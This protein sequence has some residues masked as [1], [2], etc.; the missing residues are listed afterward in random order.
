MAQRQRYSAAEVAD[1]LDDSEE[2]MMEGSDDE[3]SDLEWEEQD[4]SDDDIP[5]IP[6]PSLQLPDSPPTPLQFYPLT[7]D[8]SYSLLV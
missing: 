6:E 2:P 4:S 3:F 7:I 8:T 5:E 1:M